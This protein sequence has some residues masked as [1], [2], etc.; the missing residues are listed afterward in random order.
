MGWLVEEVL[1]RGAETEGLG[2]KALALA[3]A[4]DRAA[5]HPATIEVREG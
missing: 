5:L 3:L 1:D 2:E 4:C